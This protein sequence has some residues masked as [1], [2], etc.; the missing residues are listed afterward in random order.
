MSPDRSGNGFFLKLSRVLWGSRHATTRCD[1]NHRV[2]A[3]STWLA[4]PF[5]Y[6]KHMHTS[7]TETPAS[8]CPASASLMACSK[9]AQL[10]HWQVSRTSWTRPVPWDGEGA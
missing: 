10:L 6:S 7:S 3:S 1:E 9:M 2:Q 8:Y 4:E 5:K